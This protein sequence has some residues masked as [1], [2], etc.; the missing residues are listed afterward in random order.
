MAIF[1]IRKFG[2]PVLR[3]PAAPVEKVDDSVTK[4][5]RDLDETMRNAP[6][7]GLAAPQIG[8]SRRV[9]VWEYEENSGALANPRV[10]DRRGEVEGDEACLS[11]PGLTFPVLRAEWVRVEGLDKSGGRVTL[12]LEDWPARILQHEIDHTEGVLFIDRL[13]P[14]L[15]KEARRALR[16]QTLTGVEPTKT[17]AVL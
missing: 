9:I 5:M 11:L 15:A 12:E 10:L 8:V 4:L 13:P 1:P 14:E 6:G 16:E 2:D 7:V 17:S 3:R